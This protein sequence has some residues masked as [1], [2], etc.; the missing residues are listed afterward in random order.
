MDFETF[1]SKECTLKKL[2][3]DE[4]LAH[5]ECTV[6]AVSLVDKDGL[7]FYGDPK[8]MPGVEFLYDVVLAHNAGFER[9]VCAKLGL[10]KWLDMPWFDTADL[11]AY[12]QCARSL[13]A[14]SKLLLKGI[15][16]KMPINLFTEEQT[17]TNEKI[18]EYC[19]HD[20][21]LS[22][23][24]W[25]T[26]RHHWPHDEWILSQA[27]RENEER[28]IT[29]DVSRLDQIT[30]DAESIKKAAEAEIP[31]KPCL[32]LKKMA[33]ECNALGIPVPSTVRQES[34]ELAAWLNM[35][36]GRAP[37]IKQM[38]RYRKANRYIKL[39]DT[40]RKRIRPD[41]TVRT[42]LFYYGAECTGRYSGTAGLNFQ[43]LNRKAW[44]GTLTSGAEFSLDIRAALTARPGYKLAVADLSQI[45]P[46]VL[47]WLSGDLAFFDLL[48]V[49]GD[50]YE[51]KA[52]AM[53]L[54]QG[55]E[56]IPTDLRQMT[57]AMVL[58]LGYG[59]GART[60]VRVAKTNGIELDEETAQQKVDEFRA[61]NKPIV[62]YW[63]TIHKA[64]EA[65]VDG[66]G[67]LVLQTPKGRRMRYWDL[68]R[69]EV[70]GE[71]EIVGVSL[72]NFEPEFRKFYG[73]MLVENLTQATARDV[74]CHGTLLIRQKNIPI[75]FTAHDEV[76]CEVPEAKAEA[77]L[78]TIIECLTT[79][80][81]WIPGLLIGAEG[82][83]LDRY[84]K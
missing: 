3:L 56:K 7:V 19:I 62:D 10:K 38:N 48:R 83:I 5:P 42:A 4:Y 44:K 20:S 51:A 46:R 84:A 9:A 12:L 16:P 29:V 54:W 67:H 35:Y 23:K 70:N 24:L 61:S 43:N 21:W 79:T 8:D 11:A 32:S 69:V 47:A 59:A 50:I 17:V 37:W 13:A 78:K 49:V 68:R 45:E 33:E 77:Q 76:I 22:L 72:R 82:K 66:A 30:R 31:W 39:C 52:R 6:Y 60:F 73:A 55:P 71:E 53:G 41:G 58:G 26:F 65:A 75:L 28:G 64:L 1:V 81:R 57:K 40:I 36:E 34:Q 14:A 63:R 25:E 18:K 80:P 2:S 15:P 27:N 74:F